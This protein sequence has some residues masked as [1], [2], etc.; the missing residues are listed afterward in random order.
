MIRAGLKND[1]APVK[2]ELGQRD[3]ANDYF[4]LGGSLHGSIS[5]TVTGNSLFDLND[6]E[7]FWR[8]IGVPMPTQSQ[9]NDLLPGPPDAMPLSTT[10]LVHGAGIK[11]LTQMEL[12]SGIHLPLPP[13][14]SQVTTVMM[15][16]LPNKYTQRMLITEVNQNGFLGT[17]D[18]FYLPIDQETT[19]NRGYGFLN[20]IAP[21]YAWAFHNMFE[22]RRMSRFNSAKVVSVTPS[23]LQGFQANYMHYSSARV[24]RGDPSAR[25]LFLREPSSSTFWRR[26]GY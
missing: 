9:C 1:L 2:V 11:Q 14:W 15:R 17:F 23:T 5:G 8:S 10:P 18:F 3:A 24:N 22:G 16:N 13:E 20:F 6:I 7:S 4:K 25:P 26:S 21:Y 12:R 19:A